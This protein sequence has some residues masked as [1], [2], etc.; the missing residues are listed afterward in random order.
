MDFCGIKHI[1]ERD[2]LISLF[3]FQFV[4]EDS[5]MHPYIAVN[6]LIAVGATIMILGFLGCCGAMK[7]SRCM[8][9]VV[10]SPANPNTHPYRVPKGLAKIDETLDFCLACL[11][12]EANMFSFD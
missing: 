7:E 5:G 8:L 11:I 1:K 4:H 2:F 10:S 9:L 6:I 3:Y 12:L